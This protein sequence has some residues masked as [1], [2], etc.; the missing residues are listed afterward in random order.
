M[1]M[2]VVGAGATGGYFRL[3]IDGMQGVMPRSRRAVPK[4]LL[5]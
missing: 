4:A 3:L 2:L 1:R 5:S